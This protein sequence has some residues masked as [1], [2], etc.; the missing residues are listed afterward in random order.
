[1]LFDSIKLVEIET[2]LAQTI[3]FSPLRMTLLELFSH[4][5]FALAMKLVQQGANVL[6]ADRTADTPHTKNDSRIRRELQLPC[7]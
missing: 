6:V 1:M 3:E 2:A 5:P 7:S 4:Q